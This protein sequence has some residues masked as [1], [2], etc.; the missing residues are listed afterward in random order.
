MIPSSCDKNQCWDKGGFKYYVKHNYFGGAEGHD[1][2]GLKGCKK[3]NKY[4]LAI[5]RF[6]G[7][8]V[9]ACKNYKREESACEHEQGG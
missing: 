5:Y 9:L 8:V 1:Q 4:S 7:C 2:E 3:H 6:M